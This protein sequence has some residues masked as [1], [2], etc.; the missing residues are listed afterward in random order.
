MTRARRPGLQSL[1]LPALLISSVHCDPVFDVC[2]HVT[3]CSGGE[4]IAGVNIHYQAGSWSF[5]ED[6][7]TDSTGKYC[8]GDMGSTSPPNPYTIDLARSGYASD[9]VV[10]DGAGSVDVCLNACAACVDATDGGGD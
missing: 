8:T 5:G 1:V 6:G 2:V 3:D 7:D 10:S 4:P 9:T